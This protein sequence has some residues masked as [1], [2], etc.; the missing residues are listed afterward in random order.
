[1]ISQKEFVKSCLTKYWYEKIPAGMDWNEAHYPVPSC[2]Q[3]GT[4]V[5]L[6]RSDHAAHNVIQ[7]EEI[8]HPCVFSWE[9]EYLT[10]DY[11]YLV[12]YYHKWK[13][14]GSQIAGKKAKEQGVGI[15]SEG[16][17]SLGG[18]TTKAKGVGI[19]DESKKEQY[20]EVRRQSG[21]K[22]KEEG[23]GIFA[24]GQQS[25]GGKVTQEKKLG[26]FGLPPEDKK[27]AERK[28]GRTTGKLP[29]WTNGITNRYC[30]EQPGPDWYPGVTRKKKP[31][32][33][34]A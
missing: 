6:W 9:L 27:E 31:T 32:A 16:K 5:P 11:D 12:P 22:A 7:S 2:K 18:L 10:G 4:T 26:L 33:C 20:D 19:F 21:V 1:M 3:G 30:T 15:H 14:V 29:R 23:L 8:G 34:E 24:E 13:K 25:L 17:Q 28:G